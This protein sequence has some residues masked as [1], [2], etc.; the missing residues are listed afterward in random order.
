[1]VVTVLHHDPTDIRISYH[2]HKEG[3]ILEGQVDGGNFFISYIERF[4]ALNLENRY[5]R[6]S[7]SG[8]LGKK[9]VREC[10]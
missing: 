2:S 4:L 7:W 6:Y 10:I 5:N 9:K 8:S 3:Y 1:M